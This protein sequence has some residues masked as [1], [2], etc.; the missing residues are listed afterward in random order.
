MKAVD[1]IVICNVGDGGTCVE[2]ALNVRPQGLAALLFTQAQVMVSSWTMDVA[3]EI[4]NEEFLQVFPRVDR[5]MPQPFEPR[6]G[7]RFQ[8]HWEVY[9]FGRIRPSFYFNSSRVDT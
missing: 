2:E 9:Y 4:V 8:C 7:R 1:N 3:L 5:V 6:E